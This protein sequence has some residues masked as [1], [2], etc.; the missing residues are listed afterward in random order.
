MSNIDLFDEYTAAI[1]AELYEH[2]PLRRSIAS[3]AIIGLALDPADPPPR[4]PHELRVYEA[5]VEWLAGSGFIALS[6][7]GHQGDATLTLRGLEVMKVVPASVRDHNSLGDS[8]VSAVRSGGAAAG[9]ELVA[10]GLTQAFRLMGQG[11][12]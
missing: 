8:L 9:K 6:G 5:T 7:N 1:F 12:L 3:E 11:V 10:F 2:F 4:V